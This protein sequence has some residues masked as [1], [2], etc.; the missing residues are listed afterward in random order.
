MVKKA[1]VLVLVAGC[2][3]PEVP[4]PSSIPPSTVDRELQ[5]VRDTLYGARTVRVRFRGEWPWAVARMPQ[6]VTGTLLLGKG[7]RAKITLAIS[8]APGNTVTHEA[9]SDG[10]RL[11]RSPGVEAAKF[12]PGPA[13][14]RRELLQALAWHGI[15]WS[16]PQGP[17]PST[18][19]MGYVVCDLVPQERDLR[20]SCLERTDASLWIATHP[21]PGV[22]YRIRLSFDPATRQLRRR[23]LIGDKGTGWYAETYLEVELNAAIP[24]EEFRVPEK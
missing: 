22:D 7:D 24:D 23:E 14:L 18:I 17:H 3:S 15:G 10:T 13:G 11:W 6:S 5:K 20:P 8:Y 19:G 21:C 4:P 9:V 16:F 2:S 12:N 1:M